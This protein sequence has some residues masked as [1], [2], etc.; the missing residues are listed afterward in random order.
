MLRIILAFFFLSTTLL[1]SCQSAEPSS[2][3]SEA[4]VLSE[5]QTWEVERCNTFILGSRRS[6]NGTILGGLGFGLAAIGGAAVFSPLVVL[7]GALGLVGY[8]QTVSGSALVLRAIDEPASL[9]PSKEQI[10]KSQDVL[11]V[12][13]G[14]W[15]P[16]VGGVVFFDL[17]G[18]VVSGRVMKF[19]MDVTQFQVQFKEGDKLRRKWV[20]RKD[21]R[22]TAEKQGE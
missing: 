7:G 21:V 12:A 18:E 2:Q 14:P 13:S 4:T 10:E 3:V 11:E 17:K 6:A 19:N 5:V 16:A 8:V 15:M 20:F 9:P 1:G 22:A